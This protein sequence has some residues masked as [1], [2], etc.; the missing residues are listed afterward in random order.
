MCTVTYIPLATGFILT[1]SK[2]EKVYRPT[3][4]PAV[5]EHY[6]QKVTYPKDK[7]AGGSWIAVN[8]RN[9]IACLLNGA[10]DNH[11]KQ[12]NY[13]KSRGE[14][15]IN[16]FEYENVL[17]FKN[18]VDFTGIEP[19]T[20]LMLREYNFCEL[21]WNGSRLY[22]KEVNMTKPAI[23]S[24]ATL[25]DQDAREKRERWFYN[26][27]REHKQAADFNIDQFHTS[28]HAY[29]PESDILMKRSSGLQTLSIS[30]IRFE[31]NKN[32]FKYTD[33]QKKKGYHIF[34]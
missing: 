28:R 33:L 11:E 19:F 7:E 23:W 27:L 2:D 24:S 26:W 8:E 25:Y 20:L 15:L 34:L 21:R 30:R 18:H 9:H 14:L 32:T 22:V 17:D 3:L 5:Y 16:S 1:S 13:R 6:G 12:A 29:D 10:F 31:E 4:S